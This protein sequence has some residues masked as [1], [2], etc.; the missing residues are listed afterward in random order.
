MQV[1]SAMANEWRESLHTTKGALYAR[2]KGVDEHGQTAWHEEE[3]LD[4]GRGAL[5][6]GGQ[7]KLRMRCYSVELNATRHME[8][9]LASPLCTV[10]DA[11]EDESFAHFLLHCSLYNTIAERKLMIDAAMKAAAHAHRLHI[12]RK[13]RSLSDATTTPRTWGDM[14]DDEHVIFLLRAPCAVDYYLRAFLAKAF[15]L[16]AQ[17]ITRK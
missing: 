7:W 12:S 6:I 8:H 17:A 2:I 14:N 15:T 3:Y 13:P 10:C 4:R 16:R 9:R 11:R 1:K 5:R